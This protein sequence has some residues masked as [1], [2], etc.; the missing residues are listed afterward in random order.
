[1][2]DYLPHNM[3]LHEYHLNQS[4]TVMDEKLIRGKPLKLIRGKPFFFV[5]CLAMLLATAKKSW[6]TPMP[7]LSP[8]ETCIGADVAGSRAA[9]T[10]VPVATVSFRQ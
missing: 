4:N 8:K 10:E 3:L 1:M 9:A 2:R 5:S 7:F 6:L